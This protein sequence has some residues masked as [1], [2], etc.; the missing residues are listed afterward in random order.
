[1]HQ[2]FCVH[3]FQAYAKRITHTLLADSTSFANTHIDVAA[4]RHWLWFIFNIGSI[5]F[6]FACTFEKFEESLKF[7]Y[8][9]FHLRPKEKTTNKHARPTSCCSLSVN[10][11]ISN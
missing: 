7:N 3:A 2:H 6:P 4:I 11:K 10:Q 8:L 5:N 1:M 9:P